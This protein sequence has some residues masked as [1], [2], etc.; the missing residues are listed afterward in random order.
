VVCGGVIPPQDHAAL[1]AAG[2]AAIFGP[3]TPIPQAAQEVLR[4]IR[5]RRPEAANDGA[6]PPRHHLR[7]ARRAPPG[8]RSAWASP[9]ARR[10][11]RPVRHPQPP[12]LPRPRPLLRGH[13]ARAGTRPQVP[14]WFGWR[15]PKRRNSAT[16]SAAPPISP[17]P[18]RGPA[19]AGE[20]L[21]SRAAT[22]PGPVTVPPDGSLPGAAR[23]PT[24]ISGPP[25][26]PRRAPP[27]PRH[28]PP[29][30]EV[31]HPRAARLKDLLAGLDDPRI[32]VITADHPVPAR[33][34]ATPR[35]EVEL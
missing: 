29:G 19:R 6:R 4:L 18:W 1:K 13:R 21:P 15:R 20:A 23:F 32:K 12:P 33:L 34:F 28:T 35:G 14:R 24:L 30:A 3:G 17:P 9:R 5:S 27:R 7:L 16:G 8:P 2:V 26:A 31:G 22:S 25:A 10:P 11:A